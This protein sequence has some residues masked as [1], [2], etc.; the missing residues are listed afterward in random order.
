MRCEQSEGRT[1]ASRLTTL[2]TQGL[3]SGGPVGVGPRRRTWRKVVC[4][5][6]EASSVAWSSKAAKVIMRRTPSSLSLE[7]FES[8][9]RTGRAGPVRLRWKRR[10]RGET[11]DCWGVGVVVVEW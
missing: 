4:W 10:G 7:S 8:S 6:G 1:V 3:L 11:G 9:S 2:T 5:L